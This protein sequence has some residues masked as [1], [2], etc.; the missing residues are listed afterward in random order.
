MFSALPP[1][2][3]CAIENG[4]ISDIISMRTI[5][6]FKAKKIDPRENLPKAWYKAFHNGRI[7]EGYSRDTN[8]YVR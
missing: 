1:C 3:I 2:G 5:D 8:I 7:M 4:A 6:I